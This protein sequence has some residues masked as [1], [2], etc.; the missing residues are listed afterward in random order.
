MTFTSQSCVSLASSVATHEKAL[1]E[2]LQLSSVRAVISMPRDLPIPPSMGR[3]RCL[4]SRDQEDAQSHPFCR[5]PVLWS[6]R[7]GAQVAREMDTT[8]THNGN[9]ELRTEQRAHLTRCHSNRKSSCRKGSE[10]ISSWRCRSKRQWKQ[11]CEI[12]QVSVKLQVHIKL[13]LTRESGPSRGH[14]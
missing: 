1:Q 4:K 9:V 11:R 5:C 7:K 13:R 10:F 6:T 3:F 2:R 12:S 14:E 8:G